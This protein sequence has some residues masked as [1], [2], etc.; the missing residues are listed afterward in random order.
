MVENTNLKMD[1]PMFDVELF[2]KIY[3]GIDY[4]LRVNSLMSL[5]TNLRLSSYEYPQGSSKNDL[6]TLD[7]IYFQLT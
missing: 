4:I 5:A 3:G 6:K 2:V 7:T 1:N